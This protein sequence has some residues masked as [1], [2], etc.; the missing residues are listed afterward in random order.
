M[1]NLSAWL[2]HLETLHPEEIELGLERVKLVAAELY[3]NF[4]SKTVISIAGTNGKGSTSCFLL[5]LVQTAGKSI[6]VYSSPHLLKFNERISVNG[7][8]VE[9]SVLC[10]A[11]SRIEQARKEVSLSYFEFSTLAALLIFSE[12]ELD[13]IILEVGLGGRLDAVNIIDADIAII[14][15]IALDHTE[16]LGDTREKIAFEKAGIIRQGRAV[17]FGEDDIPVSLKDQIS[18]KSG[19]LYQIGN[20][21][22]SN[23]SDGYW[24]W[25][26]Q[27][28]K[29]NVCSY[30]LKIPDASL[31]DFFPSN[32]AMAL[33]T[34]LLLNIDVSK[35]MIEQAYNQATLKGRFQVQNRDYTLVLDVA[36]NPHAA[37]Y[38]SDNIKRYFPEHDVHIV[39]G[40]LSNKDT[41]NTLAALQE[42]S[43][44]WYVASLENSRGSETK[45]LYNE[46]QNSAQNSVAM[47]DSVQEAFLEAEQNLQ[48]NDVLLVTGSF[49]T[50]AD[51]LEMI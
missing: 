42:I 44:S 8:N 4:T 50:V 16:W 7:V 14:T 37:G 40:M 22:T 27:D 46:L 3:L 35:G 20:D 12:S 28:I 32:A 30:E 24:T 15:N 43:S 38:L 9:D 23:V 13:Y 26:G 29:Q 49:Y 17:I 45:I 5:S 21:F 19:N 11:F 39:L 1:K 34:F 10:H 33:Q 47:F 36:H 6:G 51:V 41:Q 31:L 25:Q 48:A 18:V 2:K